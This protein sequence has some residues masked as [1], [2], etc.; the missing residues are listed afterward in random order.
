MSNNEILQCGAVI[1]YC[2]VNRCQY[3]LKI[4]S[5]TNTGFAMRLLYWI[6]LDVHLFYNLSI[7]HLQSSFQLTECIYNVI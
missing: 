3:K 5:W 4:R 7:L 1:V 6:A 2:R